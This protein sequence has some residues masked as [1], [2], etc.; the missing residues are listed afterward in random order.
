MRALSA[1]LLL[2]LGVSASHAADIP[3]VVGRSE[4]TATL[5]TSTAS[6]CQ[7]TILEHYTRYAIY[8]HGFERTQQQSLIR[9]T[10]DVGS[11]CFEGFNPASV[12]VEAVAIDTHTG[13]QGKDKL[14]SFTTEGASGSVQTSMLWGLYR[15]DMPGCCGSADTIKYFSLDSGKFVASST[16]RILEID[17]TSHRDNHGISVRR[18]VTVEDN[19]AASPHARTKAIATV[20]F[21]DGHGM[22]ETLSIHAPA[23]IEKQDW[24]LADI[25]FAGEDPTRAN[26]AVAGD[27]TH[28]AMHALLKC[29]CDK[30]KDVDLVLPVALDGMAEKGARLTGPDGIT[31]VKDSTVSNP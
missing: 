31:L 19:I 3:V 30:T 17:F 6:S 24:W 18:F 22:R 26:I 2:C 14:W 9:Q 21:A 25:G 23:A 5:D 1:L 13:R 12:S 29:R 15:V 11:G 20:F 10:F 7:P 28:P 8:G 4:S 27:A 16:G